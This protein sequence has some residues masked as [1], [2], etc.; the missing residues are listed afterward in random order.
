MKMKT[1]TKTKNM[2]KPAATTKT[3]DTT[4][5]TKKTE[6]GSLDS[7][8][9]RRRKKTAKTTLSTNKLRAKNTM[10]GRANGKGRVWRTRR[11]RSQ[12]SDW[13]R[14]D[15]S[16][17]DGNKYGTLVLWICIITTWTI[18]EEVAETESERKNS[19]LKTTCK[20]DQ[21]DKKTKIQRKLRKHQKNAT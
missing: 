5:T 16:V 20:M 6:K 12:R 4:D 1:K 2:T 17:R 14:W 3:T 19:R 21:R 9:R 18:Y 7:R 11:L 13:V 10:D 8:R 15:L